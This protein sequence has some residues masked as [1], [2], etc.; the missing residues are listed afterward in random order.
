MF[1]FTKLCVNKKLSFHF[2]FKFLEN[3]RSAIQFL[4][5]SK[6]NERRRPRYLHAQLPAELRTYT[7][8]IIYAGIYT[9]YI[10]TIHILYIALLVER[11]RFTHFEALRPHV[12]SLIHTFVSFVCLRALLVRLFVRV[13]VSR[14]DDIS[15]SIL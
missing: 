11:A 2:V 13:F 15:I 3:G 7:L 12:Q 14:L 10:L 1:P 4:L 5:L 9:L 8:Y 6:S